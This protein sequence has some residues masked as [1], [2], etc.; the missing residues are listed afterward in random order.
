MMERVGRYVSVA[1][2]AASMQ[3][4]GVE[5]PILARVDFRS[6][7]YQALTWRGERVDL[8]EHNRRGPKGKGSLWNWESRSDAGTPGFA[9]L[10]LLA[11]PSG[12]PRP[13]RRQV[14]RQCRVPPPWKLIGAVHRLE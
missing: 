3:A 1:A 14:G 11:G 8:R 5:S 6:P 13:G 10:P 9:R 2:V 12:K 7:P 4:L